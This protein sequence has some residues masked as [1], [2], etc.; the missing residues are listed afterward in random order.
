MPFLVFVVVISHRIFVFLVSRKAVDS[1]LVENPGWL[2]WQYLLPESLASNFWAS[3]TYL[4]QSPPL[5]NLIFGAFIKLFGWPSGTAYAC[6]ATGGL[7]S[8]ISA[9][10]FVNLGMVFGISSLTS[11]AMALILFLSVDCF[12]MEYNSFGQTFYELLAMWLFIESVT[13]FANASKSP[14]L[15]SGVPVGLT[16]GML[17]LS[18]S[19]LHFMFVPFAFLVCFC[20]FNLRLRASLGFILAI[21]LTQGIWSLKNCFVFDYFSLSTSS[22]TGANLIAGLQKAGYGNHVLKYARRHTESLPAW[23]TEL[24]SKEG[25]AT[26]HPA[27]SS[28]YAPKHIVDKD[29]AIN[30]ALGF[31]NRSE[32]SLA[33]KSL[34]DAYIP[35]YSEFMRTHPRILFHK[36]RKSYLVYWLPIR[37]YLKQ[38]VAVYS[39]AKSQ[40]PMA[41]IDIDSQLQVAS[42]TYPA[43]I[44]N[45]V[46]LPSISVASHL[47]HIPICFLSHV[48]VLLTLARS[49]RY[50]LSLNKGNSQLLNSLTLVICIVYVSLAFNL[51]EHGENMRF[52]L[53]VE[54]LIYL[55]SILMFKD[56][57]RGCM[58]LKR[59]LYSTCQRSYRC[60]SMMGFVEGG[61]QPTVKRH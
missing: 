59:F 35:L 49:A 21:L 44:Y 13:A 58:R 1:L 50:C 23:V 55:A 11:S 39:T 28:V 46:Y 48:F 12:G 4:Q 19:G 5:P 10:R 17:S 47:L 15:A 22:W 40:S 14:N 38:F 45:D 20:A 51:V 16:I 60:N 36:F 9:A 43:L 29:L 8:A 18:R 7:I 57:W 42:G 37:D 26:W 27:V 3:L 54:P 56:I 2:T 61:M 41:L 25:L 6:I 33:Q 34:F 32:N 31:Q 24:V 52:R 53:M 30:R